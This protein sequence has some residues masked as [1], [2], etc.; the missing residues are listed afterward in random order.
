MSGCASKDRMMSPFGIISLCRQ[1]ICPS[2]HL[3]RCTEHLKGV[4]PDDVLV[5]VV[6]FSLLFCFLP[7]ILP[8]AGLFPL[9][10]VT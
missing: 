8:W 5:F 1:C 3:F 9:Q 4:V 10:V 6:R 2:N 7:F